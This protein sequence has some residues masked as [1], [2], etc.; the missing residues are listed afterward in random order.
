VIPPALAEDLADDS[1][2]QEREEAFIA[3]MVRQGHG[4]D[5]LYP[6]NAQWRSR[7]EEQDAGKRA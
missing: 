1:L 2:Q 7:F 3:E 5:G 4:V 6:M